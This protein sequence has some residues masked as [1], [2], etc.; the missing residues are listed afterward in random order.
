MMLSVMVAGVM[1][2]GCVKDSECKGDRVCEAGACVAPAPAERF[3]RT[4]RIA[5][6]ICLQSL[7]VEGQVQQSCREEGAPVEVPPPLPPPQKPRSRL[8]AD[9]LVAGGV[10]VLVA[11]GESFVLPQLTL[12]GAFGSRRPSGAGFVLVTN[13]SVGLS[14]YGAM[15]VLGIAPGLRL[16]ETSHVV[17]SLGPTL[18]AGGF[19]GDTFAGL[20]GSA[21]LQGVI[22][23]FDGFVLTP[24]AG[25]HFDLSGVIITL[26]VGVG[27]STL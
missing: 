21:L 1:A 25:L 6:Q 17:L 9:G 11:D 4:V 20:A 10:M 2:Q 24:Q 16:G 5:G 27:F 18:L 7:D 14:P 26:G 19:G 22:S 12:S 13:A 8:S 15:F 23:L 3:P